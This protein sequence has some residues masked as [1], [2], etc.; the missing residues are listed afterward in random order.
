MQGNAYVRWLGQQVRRRDRILAMHKEGISQ[1]AI[2]R[3]FRIT[4]QRVHSIIRD[5]GRK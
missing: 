4:R 2:A 3:R 5:N 1:S